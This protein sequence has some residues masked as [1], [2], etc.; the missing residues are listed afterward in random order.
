MK[1]RYWLGIAISLL[2]IYLMFRSV[3]I[4]S[5][6]EALRDAELAYLIPALLLYFCGVLVRTVRWRLL[7]SP[8]RQLGFGRVFSVVTMGYMANNIL[9]LR[10]GEGLRAFLLWK[11]EKI[12]PSAT[13]ATILVERI[14]D[15][16]VLTG[17]LIAAGIV[18]PVEGWISQLAWVAGAVFVVAVGVAFALTVIP[19]PLTRLAS[20]VL[21]PFPMRVGSLALRIL[22]T[23]VEG[24]SVLRNAR[25][26]GLVGLLSIVAWCFEAGMYLML[27]FSFPFAASFLAAVL[28]TAVANL[29]TMVPSSPGYVGTFD[30][31]L[32]SVLIGTFQIEPSLATSYTLLVHAALLLP[33]TLLGLIF[34]WREGLS[35]RRIGREVQR[36]RGDGGV[37][38]GAPVLHRRSSS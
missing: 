2:L 24:L 28:G 19:E 30:L 5:V 22:R 18:L 38:D 12:A 34:L 32:S 1:K 15:G 26:T 16:L 21:A 9:P 3:E 35:L 23:F 4:A 6:G 11:R 20:A 14:F 27:M 25:E 29:G 33:I 7:L 37:A 8:V 31:P 17:F 10:A 36:H 13:V